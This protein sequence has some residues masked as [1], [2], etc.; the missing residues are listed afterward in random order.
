MASP[1]VDSHVH[2]WDPPGLPYPWLDAEPTI[3]RAHVPSDLLTEAGNHA[4]RH[5]VFVQAGCERSRSLD[6]VTW[7]EGL[8][9]RE[10]KIAAIVAFAPVDEGA[11]TTRA[12][13]ALCERPLV[14]GVRHLIQDATDPQ[15]CQ[16]PAFVDGVRSVGQRGLCFELCLRKEQ[17]PA[18]IELVRACPDT[19]FVLDHAG[20][21][22]IRAARLD[23][24]RAD[25]ETIA[26]F[27]RVVCK[28]SGL[29]TEA[30]AT[31]WT[32][33]DLRPY[34]EHVIACFGPG[35]LLFGSDWPVVKL[36]STYTRWLESARA[37]LDRLAP[38]DR[39]AIF[40]DNARRTYRI[41]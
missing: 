11:A 16:R 20:K 12:L 23:P 6:E 17:L 36:A 10:P 40:F 28:L 21:P 38:A 15:L 30:H 35:R 33:D 2:F 1:F 27:P 29:V 32:P 7:V 34:V 3:S 25:I 39:D 9:E 13:D 19:R 4:P 8:A 41:P 24:W 22:D 14:R 26:A 18:A 31:A 5:I 37:L